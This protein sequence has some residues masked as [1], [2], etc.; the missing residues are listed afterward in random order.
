MYRRIRNQFGAAGAGAIIVGVLLICMGLSVMGVKN[1]YLLSGYESQTIKFIPSDTELYSN[2]NFYPVIWQLQNVKEENQGDELKELKKA[3]EEFEEEHGISLEEVLVN[4]LEPEVS[5]S[6]T[7]SRQVYKYI[8]AK[9]KL[10]NS[11]DEIL[12]ISRNLEFYYEM[13]GKYP[14]SLEELVPD[15]MEELP[16]GTEDKYFYRVEEEKNA[17]ILE[18]AEDLHKDGGVSGKYPAYRGEKGKGAIIPCTE[19]MPEYAYPDWIMIGAVKDKDAIE[20]TLAEKLPGGPGANEYK[21]EEIVTIEKAK[22]SYCLT[23]EF[24]LIANKEDTIKK[25]LDVYN[26]DGENV[27]ENELYKAFKEKMPDHTLAYSFVNLDV[28][29]PHVYNDFTEG[30]SKEL[31]APALKALKSFGSIISATS[32]GLKMDSYL[33]IDK[34]TDSTLIKLIKKQDPPQLKSLDLIPEDT[35]M[36]YSTSEIKIIWEAGQEILTQF[37]EMKEKYDMALKMFTSFTQI[38]VEEDLI[39]NF[40]GELTTSIT[41]T[42]EYLENLKKAALINKC[43]IDLVNIGDA[44]SMYQE[45]HSGE[46]PKEIDALIPDYL[47]NSPSAPENGEY[48]IVPIT[49]EELNRILEEET[50]IESN[51]SEVIIDSGETL[52]EGKESVEEEAVTEETSNQEEAVTDETSN[53]EEAVTEPCNPEENTETPVVENKYPPFYIAYSGKLS[54]TNIKEDYPRYYSHKGFTLGRDEKGNEINTPVPMPDTVT[55]LGIKDKESLVKLITLGSM[56]FPGEI[57]E[58]TYRGLTYTELTNSGDLIKS[59][60]NICYAFVDGYFIM[61]VGETKRPMEKTIDTFRKN[62]KPL[63]ENRDY[64]IAIKNIPSENLSTFGFINLQDF[65]E[66]SE[67][68][69]DD[70][71]KKDIL[72]DKL[73]EDLEERVMDFSEKVSYAWGSSKVEKD[74]FHWSIYIPLN[75]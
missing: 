29:L 74:G 40:S 30:V 46:I 11:K 35:T 66:I 43:R 33:N 52:E 70:T 28:I 73:E 5:F 51:N 49:E 9:V 57:K 69:I 25:S 22:V 4:W 61:T 12:S 42:P 47:D 59:P 55:I 17:F 14:D 65:I 41:S 3:L 50:E 56:F 2:I 27:E 26:G 16:E 32:G 53:Q 71:L 38:D 62:L 63:T 58:N 67:T 20:E 60:F 24:L 19:E 34:D 10:K 39:A 31:G 45:D 23:D 36:V 48:I 1:Y 72:E 37:P 54:I 18:A 68:G 13:N 75:F 6:A 15:Y 7:G 8:K 21:G 64:K 44:L